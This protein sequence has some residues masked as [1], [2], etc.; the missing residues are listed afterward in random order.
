MSSSVPFATSAVDGLLDDLN[1]VVDMGEVV[2]SPTP[3]APVGQ[4]G[5]EDTTALQDQLDD[6]AALIAQQQEQLDQYFLAE[7]D[8]QDLLADIVQN[9]ESS[10]ATYLYSMDS[11]QAQYFVGI[12]CQHPFADYVSWQDDDGG[13]WLYYGANVLTEGGSYVHVYRTSGVGYKTYRIDTG[14]GVPSGYDGLVVSNVVDGAAVFPEPAFCRA[15]L[16]VAFVL[17]VSVGLALLRHIFFR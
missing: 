11:S 16:L 10:T 2:P 15:G 14:T 9:L 1:G 5:G 13:Y 17:C 6:Q 12:L 8:Q 4:G 7:Q 3:G